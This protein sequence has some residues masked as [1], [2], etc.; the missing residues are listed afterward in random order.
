MFP[1]LI[2]KLVECY[3]HNNGLHL[4]YGP[5]ETIICMILPYCWHFLMPIFEIA[6]V[7][8][9]YSCS[10]YGHG[11]RSVFH[12]LKKL[13]WP[14]FWLRLECLEA[15]EPLLA[16][17]LLLTLEVFKS[18]SYSFDWSAKDKRLVNYVKSLKK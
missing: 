15:V 4:D 3:L 17:S 18:S 12:Q 8:W 6:P 10:G 1:L 11:K 16:D 7:N 9:S 2:D 5:N 13:L 14:F